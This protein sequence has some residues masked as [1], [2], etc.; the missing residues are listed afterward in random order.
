MAWT[1]LRRNT[2]AEY[3][4]E[5]VRVKELLGDQAF[6]HIPSTQESGWVELSKIKNIYPKPR[7]IGDD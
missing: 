2:T 6:I 7:I 1:L 3:H 5:K 4:N